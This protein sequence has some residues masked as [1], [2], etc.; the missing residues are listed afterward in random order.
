[1]RWSGK[2]RGAL[3]P[4]VQAVAAVCIG[5]AP[6][7]AQTAWTVRADADTL[8][9]VVAPDAD[10]AA[11]LALARLDA[12]GFPLARADSARAPTLTA[13]GVVFVT[14]GPAA[15][16][17]RVAIVG[18]TALGERDLTAGWATRTGAPYRPDALRADLARGLDRYAARGF[19]GTRLVPRVRLVP[20]PG[21]VAV[22]VSV[23]VSE[24]AAGVVA[25]VELVG[26]RRASRAFAS[27]VAGVAPGTPLADIDAAAVRRDLEQTGLYASVGEPERVLDADGRVVLRVPVVEA[28]PGVFDAVL[29]YLPPSGGQ[30][31][32]IVGTGRVE[33]RNP[34]GGGRSGRVA[35]DRTPGLGSTVQ[36]AAS[37]PFVLGL[38]VRLGAAFDGLSRD[39]TFSRQT[40]R[41]DAGVRAGPGLELTAALSREAVAPGRFG[42]T[43]VDGVVRVRRSSAVFAGAGV[44]YRRLP[45]GLFAAPRRGLLVEATVE[46]GIRRRAAASD[47]VA[48]VAARQQRLVATVR[49]YVPTFA[50]QSVAFG[51]D[52]RVLAG[53]QTAGDTDETATDEGE[54]F[55]LGG[56]QSLRGTDEDALLGT[57]VGRVF[58]EP[59]L[60]V[61]A[62][63]FVF[64]FFDLGYV[65]QP[66]LPGRPAT[67]G[68]RPGYGG[69]ARLRTGLGLV[70]LTY[71]LRPDLPASRGRVHVGLGFG[72]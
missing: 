31:G 27:R 47:S 67:R 32:Q 3:R 64:A 33:L 24:G 25:G 36:I 39:S 20:T 58:V 53:G 35:F 44:R 50:R 37:D 16:V 51:L 7:M 28:P 59:R 8:A 4:A 42:T 54:L 12:D 1:M 46:S 56:A 29:G 65:D 40:V 15:T 38:P 61:D 70:T 13:P 11:R 45:G 6:A 57:A 41:V 69:G 14:R 48:A 71:A 18:A 5:A 9:A 2:I 66:D 23:D 21:A 52:A 63:S 17:A 26:A 10:G 68:A 49:L 60:H 55:R 43:A 30:R 34:F 72:L 22:E 19:V 62:E